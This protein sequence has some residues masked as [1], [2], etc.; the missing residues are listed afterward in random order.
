[1]GPQGGPEEG[2]LGSDLLLNAHLVSHL[3]TYYQP[4]LLLRML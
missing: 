4:C 3:F 1:M 2:D